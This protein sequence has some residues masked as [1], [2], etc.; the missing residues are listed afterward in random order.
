VLFLGEYDY[1][2]DAKQRLAIPA[3][4]RDVLN[5]EVHGAAFI[6]APGGN[7]SLWLWPEKTFERLSTEFDSS[8]LGDDQLDDFERLM[9]SQAARVPLDSSGRV[10]LPA[11]L[12][13]QYDLKD[14]VK[15]LGVRD[16]LELVDPAD[17]EAERKRL[18]PAKEEMIKSARRTMAD[19]RRKLDQ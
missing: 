3:E 11:R 10:R 4:V 9:F 5:P 2:I 16:H 13:A 15:V 19:R 18:E 12:L 8:L 1:T 7:G 17:W 14:A 6:A